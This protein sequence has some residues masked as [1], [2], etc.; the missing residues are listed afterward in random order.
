MARFLDPSREMHF[1]SIVLVVSST[2]LFASSF[3]FAASDPAPDLASTAP[4]ASAPVP[5]ASDAS[6]V[7]VV[8]AP[9]AAADTPSGSAGDKS[10]ARELN[11]VYLSFSPLH[12]IF[13]VVELMA[14]VRVH[15]RIGVAAIGAFGNVKTAGLSVPV[16]EAGGQFVAYPVGNFD[17]GMQL[18][19]ELLY[20]GASAETGAGQAKISG[21]ATGLA[22]G[23]FVGYKLATKVGFSFNVQAGASYLAATGTA[24]NATATATATKSESQ[25]LPLVNANVGWSF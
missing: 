19:A 10:T 21:S 16:W 3:A 14:E 15:P 20:L 4:P 1:A 5:N 8:D 18:G 25:W 12:L 7:A 23:A 6:T 22:T 11:R 13:P 24:S 9:P 2:S 17:H